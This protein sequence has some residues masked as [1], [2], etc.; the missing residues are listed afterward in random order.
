MALV[1]IFLDFIFVTLLLF[2][3]VPGRGYPVLLY[4]GV[5]GSIFWYLTPEDTHGGLGE[6]LD[7][8]FITALLRL[9]WASAVIGIVLKCTYRRSKGPA[10]ATAESNTV[11]TADA[12]LLIL[13]GLS[14]PLLD[15]AFAA[16]ADALPGWLAILIVSALGIGGLASGGLLCSRRPNRG[17]RLARGCAIFALSFG[18][19][20]MGLSAYSVA[21]AL[22]VK[23]Q[24]R[25]LA[26]GNAYCLQVVAGR[27]YRHA[28][29]WLD[30]S[31]L[32]MRAGPAGV[33]ATPFHAILTIRD[34]GTSIPYYWSWRRWGFLTNRDNAAVMPL[35]CV[36]TLE[37]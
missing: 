3:I 30:L 2:A 37:G 17:A 36:P 14:L 22:A 32:T 26:A 35:R 8:A 23:V 7:E 5:L 11:H 13:V 31:P 9:W 24:A 33:A 34:A 1:F 27:D 29:S 12:L 28:Q 18:L 25:K 10:V 6:S 16:F 19:S 4:L 20:A 21:G 15:L